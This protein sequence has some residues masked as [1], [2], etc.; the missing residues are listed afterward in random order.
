MEDIYNNCPYG[1]DSLAQYENLCFEE[2]FENWNISG[3]SLWP[4]DWTIEY[5]GLW[6]GGG[7]PNVE[8]VTSLTEGNFAILLRSNGPGFEGPERTIIERQLC[9][10]PSRVDIA[11]TYTCRGDGYCEV[12]LGQSSEPTSGVNHRSIWNGHTQDTIKRTVVLNNIPVNPPFLGFQTIQF[13]ANPVYWTGGSWG[14]SEF[15]IDSLVVREYSIST[16]DASL[17]ESSTLFTIYPNP[18]HDIFYIQSNKFEAPDLVTIYTVDGQILLQRHYD[19]KVDL[20]SFTAG[21]YIL[22]I[23]YKAERII[24]KVV[25]M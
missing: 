3:D 23:Q 25:K 13:R 5:P 8:R 15:T 11:F 21:I 18:S 9:D 16:G 24:T 1:P 17:S 7:E 12:V 4:N 2:G 14:I 22:E 19:N 20:S 6:I 10:F